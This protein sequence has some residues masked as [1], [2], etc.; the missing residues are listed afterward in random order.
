MAGKDCEGEREE[1]EGLI[2]VRLGWGEGTAEWRPLGGEVEGMEQG[3][4]R[5]R[6]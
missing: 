6:L 3:G 4:H 5:H 1:E 2:G